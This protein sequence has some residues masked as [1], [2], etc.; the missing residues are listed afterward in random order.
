MPNKHCHTRQAAN[1]VSPSWHLTEV[2]YSNSSHCWSAES[3]Q[4]N[5]VAKHLRK[6][7]ILQLKKM[8]IDGLLLFSTYCSVGLDPWFPA[9]ESGPPRGWQSGFFGEG[10]SAVVF[11][12]NCFKLTCTAHW[13]QCCLFPARGW[14]HQRTAA[15]TSPSPT[16]SFH[17]NFSQ[18][19]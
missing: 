11:S 14:R 10:V 4:A 5:C 1:F 7:E 2:K 9:W 16:F 12:C 8:G 13:V 18:A 19:A 15:I 6:P 3:Q 17:G